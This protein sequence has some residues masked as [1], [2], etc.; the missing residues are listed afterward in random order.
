VA[1]AEIGKSGFCVVSMTPLGYPDEQPEAV[2]PER[3]V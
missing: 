2:T 1:C 3:I